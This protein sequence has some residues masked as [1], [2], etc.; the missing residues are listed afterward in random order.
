M[1][2]SV[3]T[4]V[5]A[6]SLFG[7]AASEASIVLN[8]TFEDRS[9]GWEIASGSVG[10][11]GYVDGEYEI[12][13]DRDSW[14]RETWA[15]IEDTFFNLRVEATGYFLADTENAEFG[16][17]WGIGPG[18]V[19]YA[20]IRSSGT[21][22]IGHI[23]DGAWQEDLVPW[24]ESPALLAWDEPNRLEIEV[25][26]GTVTFY[27]NGIELIST[28]LKME[29]PYSV[30]LYGGTLGA[31]PGIVRI[32]HYVVEDLGEPAIEATSVLA[33]SFEDESTGWTIGQ[34]DEG[35]SS[36][37]DGAYEIATQRVYGR[38]VSWAPLTE[39]LDSF[40]VRVSAQ[41]QAGRPQVEYGI[42]FGTDSDHAYYVGVTE[43]GEYSIGK[44]DAGMWE[45]RPID[46]T[47]SESIH[48]GDGMNTLELT[49]LGRQATLT[50][51]DAEPVSIDLT[52]EGPFHVGLYVS[53]HSFSSASVRFSSVEIDEL[54]EPE[55]PKVLTYDFDDESSGW[56]VQDDFLSAGRYED[57]DYVMEIKRR[58]WIRESWAPTPRQYETFRAEVTGTVLAD[59]V[60]TPSS[61]P[62]MGISFS[63]GGG[64]I[65]EIDVQ[66]AADTAYYFCVTT[67]G[68][69]S[70]TG[71]VNREWQNA[72]VEWTESSA[73]RPAGEP[74][75]I[76]VVVEDRLARCFINSVEV[77]TF[78]IAFDGPYYVGTHAFTSS[79]PALIARV[80]RFEVEDL[81]TGISPAVSD[82]REA[83]E[84]L[85]FDEF[86][87]ASYRLHALREPQ[88]IASMGLAADF[89][90]RNDGLDTYTYEYVQDTF[91]IELLILELLRT[92][93]PAELTTDQRATYQVC[94]WYWDDA[95]RGQAFYEYEHLVHSMTAFSAVGYVEYVLN[96]AHPFETEAD[97][98][99][100]LIRMQ[101]VG[102]QF[103]QLIDEMQRRSEMGIVPP[104]RT[105]EGALA[106]LERSAISPADGH[107]FSKTLKT[108]A[109]GVDGLSEDDLDGYMLLGELIVETS[110]Q[111]AYQ[112]LHDAVAEL[113]EIAPEEISLGALDGGDEAYAY[114]LRHHT[115]TELTALEIHALGL[116][117]VARVQEEIRQA[118][119]AAG[120][121][122]TSSMLAIFEA[123]DALSD[124]MQGQYAVDYNVQ[125]IR[126]AER[127]AIESGAFSAL[128]D[129]QVIVE[130]VAAGGFYSPASLDGSRPG[131]FL[132]S[133]AS[134]AE[135]YKMPTVAYHEA[136]PGHHLQ[137][138]LVREMGLPLISRDIVLNGYVEGWALYAERLMSE[139]GAFE[140]DPLGDLGRLQLELMRAVRLVVDT[141]IHALGW[142]YD[143]A[144][145]Y[146]QETVGESEGLAAYRVTR[147]TVVPGQAT[148][149]MVGLLEI[150]DLRDMAQ[151]ALGE[152]FDLADFHDVVLGSGTVPLGFLRELVDAWIEDQGT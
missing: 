147:Y 72:S 15:P 41:L 1:A 98:A 126:D 39:T 96:D 6:S 47:P 55:A 61:A 145:A 92:Y 124:S 13:I 34:D 3:L 31:A 53:S 74:N 37:Q 63:P 146:V 109:A 78:E 11:V 77:T 119:E 142:T 66:I 99:D 87:E 68:G 94:E 86:V 114:L 19:Y 123:A 136:V 73:V 130:G 79:A 21:Y 129:A 9:N 93:D 51:N 132:A 76:A 32:T 23:L 83:L 148:S 100:Y 36:Y 82:A 69:F 150:I 152:A 118:A 102:V 59:S 5:V 141:G 84:G 105:L 88:H 121:E 120:I 44:A 43:E 8:E 143:E 26:E 17:C 151:E 138:A 22:A 71:T 113:A 35:S 110:V 64:I 80:S 81:D 57:G 133:T 104:R 7:A 38:R 89:G 50:I 116:R 2:F 103:D 65:N 95:V 140:D 111:P 4:L 97:V 134:A 46:W 144:V 28:A 16:I 91:A 115:Q 106:A 127:R 30:G 101:R 125:L 107:S 67:S 10:S 108:K 122:D 112:R 54:V 33:D 117:E 42:L 62:S 18:S 14:L 135:L 12:R 24:T 45:S 75:T 149:Y 40:T 48:T 139:L 85:A 70:V 25:E 137:T 58:A 29:G 49:V 131:K 52:S 56:L 27:A 128:P 90:V 60:Q 20:G